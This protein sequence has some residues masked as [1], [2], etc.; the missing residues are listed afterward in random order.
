MAS[1]RKEEARGAATQVEAFVCKTE[2]LLQEI[3]GSF[4]THVG[5]ASTQPQTSN[6]YA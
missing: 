1:K 2:G 3:V 6:A 5:G 4:A